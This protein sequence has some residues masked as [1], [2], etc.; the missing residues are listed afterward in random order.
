MTQ[1]DLNR[2]VARATGETVREIER[3]GFSEMTAPGSGIDRTD[4]AVLD[5][6]ALDRLLAGDECD[7]EPPLL[8]VA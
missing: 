5:W 2:A 8:A 3:L 7:G 6:D 4:P 1:C